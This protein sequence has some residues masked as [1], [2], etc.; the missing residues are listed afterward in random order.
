MTSSAPLKAMLLKAQGTDWLRE[1]A[2]AVRA[3]LDGRFGAEAD[4]HLPSNEQAS[5]TDIRTLPRFQ[6]ASALCHDGIDDRIVGI[7]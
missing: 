4:W 2:S 3:I 1:S 7:V 5:R 6:D